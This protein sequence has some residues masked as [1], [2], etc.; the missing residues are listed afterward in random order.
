MRVACYLRVSTLDQVQGYSL[1]MQRERLEAYCKAQGW[2]DST[3][4]MDDGETATN[5]NR[6]GMRRM[7]RHIEEKKIDAVIVLKLDRLSRKQKD[8]LYLLEDVFEKH[9]VSFVSAT[10][11][12]NTGTP[13]GKAMIGV[14]AV[15]AQL[16]RD[17]IVERTVGG[18]LQRIRGGKWHGGHAPFGYTWH[19]SGDFLE[20]VPDE[21][22]TVREVFERFLDGESYSQLGKWAQERHP[23]HTFDASVIKRLLCRPAYAG[24]MLYSGTMYESTTEPILD[25]ETWKK[26][27][28]EIQ[29]RNDGLPPRGEYLL[30]GLCR[31]ALCGSSVVHETKQYKHKSNGRLY[32]KDYICCKN[33]KFKPYSCNMGYHQRVKVEDYVIN[34]IKNM[35]TH[36]DDIKNESVDNKQDNSDIIAAL[37]ARINVA[38]TG[39][40]NLM[41]AIQIGA[42][43]ASAVAKRIKDLEEEKESAEK[44]MEEFKDSEAAATTETVDVSLI[45]E[46]GDAWDEWSEEEQKIMLRKIVLSIKIH[47]RGTNPEITFNTY[48]TPITL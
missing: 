33:Q 2:D 1:D 12:F 20:M 36:M 13:L 15:F 3:F 17:M 31:C 5:L 25:A 41:E 32:Y 30:T 39:L 10:E 35:S 11:P 47:S 8:V 24:K 29:R 45:Q 23:T 4:Y 42:V 16:E 37:E 21:A 34:M 18:K 14:L 40:E 43:K 28:V 48:P 22:E 19:E 27:Q 44:L 38:E 26:S 46:I 7:I 9:G 6:P